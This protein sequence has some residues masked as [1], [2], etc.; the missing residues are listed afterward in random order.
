VLKII[1]EAAVMFPVSFCLVLRRSS[2]VRYGHHHNRRFA[3]NCKSTCE[4]RQRFHNSLFQQIIPAIRKK[5]EINDTTGNKVLLLIG[6]SGGCDSTALF[7]LARQAQL[8]EESHRI[9]LHMVHFDHQQR[10]TSSD[11]D[12][13]SVQQMCLDYNLDCTIFAWN[14]QQ[15]KPFSQEVA[16]DWRRSE[17]N[18]L[19]RRLT[20]TDESILGIVLTA[21]H[22]DDS[23]E[24]LLLKCLRGA[25]ITN[26]QGMPAITQHDGIYWARPLLSFRKI[27]LA[28]YLEQNNFA[29]RE[30]ESNQSNKY[31]R[32]R[33]R[34]ELVPLLQELSGSVDG[35][36]RRLDYLSQQ[37]Q[38]LGGFISEHAQAYLNEHCGAY[39]MLP[40]NGL[41]N[42]VHKEALVQWTRQHSRGQQILT[43][44]PLQRICRQL[45]MYP[46][47]RHWIV[48]I[49]GVW[50]I[51]RQGTALVLTTA[52]SSNNRECG[53]Q[54]KKD[55]SWRK[56]D[57]ENDVSKSGST[58]SL[59][60]KLPCE[61]TERPLRF[62]RTS[63]DTYL[64][65]LIIPAWRENPIKLKDFL[66]GQ[67]VP[68]HQRKDTIIILLESDIGASD[69]VA[70]HLP[71]KDEW[72]V[73]RVFSGSKEGAETTTIVIGL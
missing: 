31:L 59:R 69:I 44:E 56:G 58:C 8:Q 29:W 68:I 30:D 40:E 10:G 9:R 14:V 63:A 52:D 72:A 42:V 4:V 21:H 36:Q 62:V 3:T 24:T 34:N 33:V 18:K 53:D 43:Y 57:L 32:N 73:N 51:Q 39:F 7:H 55:L 12:R 1:V 49:G 17:T 6:V 27:K 38:E 28:N 61:L 11:Q 5:Q 25:Y 67:Q 48:N 23:N 13:E 20:D 64:N 37:S 50:N 60:I 41:L 47:N 15:N 19:L 70:V 35:F 66:R 26:L 2:F 16:R 54:Q 46:Y 22:L 71:T 45:E 65:Y